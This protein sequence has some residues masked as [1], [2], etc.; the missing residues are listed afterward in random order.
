MDDADYNI[1]SGEVFNHEQKHLENVEGA[2]KAEMSSITANPN[3]VSQYA[4]GGYDDG[5]LAWAKRESRR[6]FQDRLTELDGYRSKP[7]KYRVDI[8]HG[9]QSETY[10]LGPNDVLLDGGQQVISYN[11]DFG[12]ELINYQTIKVRK[13]GTDYGI[14]LSRQFDI[15]Q[16]KLY[17]YMNLRTDE[18]AIFKSG[19]TDPF[20]IRVLNM[21]KRQHNLTDI[22][23]TIQENQNRIVNADFSSNIIVQG[24]AGSGKTMVLLHRLSAL[25]YH[26]RHFDFSKDALILTPNDQFALHI[27]AIS[28]ELKIGNIARASVQQYYLD[29][30]AA[31]SPEFHLK[32]ALSSEMLVQQDFVDYVYSDAFRADFTAA[33]DA[34]MS[35]RNAL[36]ESLN[37]L[38]QSMGQPERKIDLSDDSRV[39]QQLRTGAKA[40][41]YLVEQRE[42]ALSDAVEDHEKQTERKRHLAERVALCRATFQ[43]QLARARPAFASK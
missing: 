31:Y 1:T 35:E 20:L 26:E 34:V 28:E 42:R 11:S 33:Y 4:T 13:D 38:A 32:E 43:R 25:Q 24:C 5:N 41:R 8:A 22:F 17:G 27:K 30:L 16:A 21:R 19:I 40:L 15:D 23:V 2:I 36:A 9:E 12:R 39:A 10:Y 37:Q 7:Y 3:Y 18:D 6:L 14:K 29:T